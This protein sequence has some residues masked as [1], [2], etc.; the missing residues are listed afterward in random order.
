MFDGKFL[1]V[2]I[3]A[4]STPLTWKLLLVRMS[5]VGPPA[6]LGYT[7][8]QQPLQAPQIC[9]FLSQMGGMPDYTSYTSLKCTR[10]KVDTVLL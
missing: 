5:V 7:S 9:T 1:L 10:V 8:N 4:F 3:V 6:Y 2:R